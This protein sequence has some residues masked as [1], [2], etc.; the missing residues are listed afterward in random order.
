[1]YYE[2]LSGE[3]KKKI[4]GRKY[5]IKLSD[6]RYGTGISYYHLNHEFSFEKGDMVFVLEQHGAELLIAP[7]NSLAFAT[8]EDDPQN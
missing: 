6:G 2:A 5:K 7:Y 4:H 1:M 3:I 8:N